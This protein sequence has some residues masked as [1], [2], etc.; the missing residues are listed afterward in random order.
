MKEES[1]ATD[2]RDWANE[3]VAIAEAATIKYCVRHASS[4]NE[5]PGAITI[6][7]N[8]VRTNAPVLREQLQKAGVRLAHLLETALHN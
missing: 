6:D 2:P 7:G 5:P 1:S 8:Y 4:C 3:S